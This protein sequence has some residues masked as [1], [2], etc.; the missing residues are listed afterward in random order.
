MQI[1]CSSGGSTGNIA[2]AI[3]KKLIEDG[4]ESYIFFGVGKS[5]EKNICRISK[6]LFVRIHAVLSRVTGLQ[7]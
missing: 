3:H 1:N 7:Y 4:N 5:N 2:K 6:H